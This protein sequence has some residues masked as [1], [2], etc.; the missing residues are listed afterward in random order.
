MA[1]G[2][3]RICCSVEVPVD[4][5]DERRIGVSTVDTV[6]ICQ[7]GDLCRQ[8]NRRHR[9]KHGKTEQ[10]ENEMET[11]RVPHGFSSREIVTGLTLGSQA[12]YNLLQITVGLSSFGEPCGDVITYRKT[13]TRL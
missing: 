2:S 1:V 6:K 8:G 13:V 5:L 3:A 12:S 11:A 7:G 4:T 10:Q 9:T